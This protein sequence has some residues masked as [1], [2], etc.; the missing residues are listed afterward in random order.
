MAF[1]V[2]VV[3]ATSAMGAAHPRYHDSLDLKHG[4]LS[5]TGGFAYMN[6]QEVFQTFIN[7]TVGSGTLI[8]I[9][10]NSGRQVLVWSD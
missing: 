4:G 3:P 5:A 6:E 10:E 1:R 2:T 7:E 9:L 8:Q